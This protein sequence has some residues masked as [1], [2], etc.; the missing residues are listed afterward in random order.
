MVEISPPEY[1]HI[2]YRPNFLT[3]KESDGLYNLLMTKYE[4]KPM[5]LYEENGES[6]YSDFLKRMF[7]SE[8]LYNKNIFPADNWGTSSVYPPIL[9]KVKERI[10]TLTA[11]RLEIAVGILYPD[12]QTGVGFHSDYPA[13]GDTSVIASLSLGAERV[14]QL[15][16]KASGMLHEYLLEHGSLFIMGEKC[17][18]EYEHALPPDPDCEDV[19][20]NLTFRCF[21]YPAENKNI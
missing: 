17:Q 10:Q 21:G 11:R 5:E 2:A 15:R 8:E 6:V 3:K 1:C 20:I 16:H 19:R 18:E 7:L 9:Y 13:F 4:F 14:F 12:G